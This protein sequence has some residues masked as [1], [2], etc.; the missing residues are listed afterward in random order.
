MLGSYFSQN[1]KQLA[2]EQPVM[3]DF[4]G[5]RFPGLIS[6]FTLPSGGTSD[7]A[8]EM[9]HA[10]ARNEPYDCF[11]NPEARIPFLVM[12]DAIQALLRLA[13]APK[14]SLS[15]L[16]Y[17]VSS[18]SL[19][20]TEIRDLVL[21]AFPKAEIRFVVDDQRQAIIDTWPADLDDTAGRRDWG[22]Q[23]EFDVERSFHEYL[24][25]N[26]KKMYQA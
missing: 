3:L 10:A 21:D 22:W 14:D 11:V 5:V 12:P 17:N 4:R 16:V 20:A 18:F 23:P 24:I 8:P 2:A 6:A 25:P 15:R 9:I 13:R 19:S 7:Y 26:I 1:Y